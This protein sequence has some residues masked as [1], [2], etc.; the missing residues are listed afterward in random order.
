MQYPMK[1]PIRALAKNRNTAKAH[2]NIT[3]GPNSDEWTVTLGSIVLDSG[4]NYNHRKQWI[5][6]RLEFLAGLGGPQLACVAILPGLAIRI[7]PPS[8]LE[9]AGVFIPREVDHPLA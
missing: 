2:T 1:Q 5:Q 3:A 7:D 4:N 8:V 9:L 6:R